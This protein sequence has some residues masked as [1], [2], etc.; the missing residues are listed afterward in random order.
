MTRGFLSDSPA[1]REG[2]DDSDSVTV[3]VILKRTLDLSFGVYRPDDWGKM[4][5]L[6]RSMVQM[7]GGEQPECK[8]RC[9][10]P[11]WM[12]TKKGLA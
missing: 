5:W 11:A 7:V 4:I 3:D 2:N 9:T 10:L 12:A 8:A 6:P 1:Q